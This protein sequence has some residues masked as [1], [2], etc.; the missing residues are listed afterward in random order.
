M[1]MRHGLRSFHKQRAGVTAGP[2][3]LAGT[4][5]DPSLIPARGSRSSRTF[6]DADVFYLYTVHASHVAIE[7]L[8]YG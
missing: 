4:G 2:A 5:T 7:P 3:R 1:V 6:C 8:K